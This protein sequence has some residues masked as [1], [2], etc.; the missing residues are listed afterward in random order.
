MIQ[1]QK[2][3]KNILEFQLLGGEPLLNP[4]LDKYIVLTRKYFPATQIIIVTNGLLIPKMSSKLIDI[5]IENNAHFFI[6][7]YPPTREM[8][9]PITDVLEKNRIACILSPPRVQFRRWITLKEENG[10]KAFAKW[11][12]KDCSC[13]VID[14]GRI[15]I[16]PCIPKLYSM[17]EYL[18][19]DI[20]EQELIDSSI[21]LMDDF[22]DGW[23]ILC[24][25][26]RAT[27]LCRFCCPEEVLEKWEVG[28]P[29]RTDYFAD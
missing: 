22:V 18:N 27:P 5:I 20:E 6:T 23:D 12:E 29:D 21:D 13:H 16:C 9:N 1:L 11:K 26:E 17:K 8:L 15:Y 3:F 7:Q 19:I 24:Y 25:Y 28:L 10:E 14:K 2:K 4:Q